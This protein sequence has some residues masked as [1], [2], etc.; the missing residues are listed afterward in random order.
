MKSEY[1]KLQEKIIEFS[2]EVL[3]AEETKTSPEM[4]VAISRLVGS[5]ELF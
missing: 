1:E 3:S 2:I 4:V 5:K